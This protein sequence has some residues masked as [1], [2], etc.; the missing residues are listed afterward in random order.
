MND[1]LF[2]PGTQGELLVQ[3]GYAA[4]GGI[5]AKTVVPCTQNE[6]PR[7]TKLIFKYCHV[8]VT[9]CTRKGWPA[10]LPQAPER[11]CYRI[12][13][14]PSLVKGRAGRE[15]TCCSE[16]R[17]GL[18]GSEWLRHPWPLVGRWIGRVL[19]RGKG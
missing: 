19:W 8:L 6:M 3:L 1:F 2:A 7:R 4:G 12:L 17:G 18:A 9:R 5:D 15:M 16:T 14:L 13:C 10:I 11:A